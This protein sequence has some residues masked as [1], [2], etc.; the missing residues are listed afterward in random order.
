[1]YCEGNLT[2]A[3]KHRGKKIKKKKEKKS[4][5]KKEGKRQAKSEREWVISYA[6]ILTMLPEV[7]IA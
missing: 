2:A 4:K 5:E 6:N 1:M 7:C 3:R